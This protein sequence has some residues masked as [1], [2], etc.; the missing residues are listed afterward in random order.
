MAEKLLYFEDFSVGQRFTNGGYTISKEAAI[1]FAKQY[2]PQF[3]HTDEDAARK[4][5]FGRLTVCGMHTMAI[6]MRL[7]M[8]S[9]FAHVAGGLIGMGMEQM[10]WPRPVYPD[11]TLR[12]VIT[13]TSV[14]LSKSKPGSG[15]VHYILETFNQKDEVVLELHTAVIMPCRKNAAEH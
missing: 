2:D 8:T 5:F 7:K 1:A 9:D 13:V 6:T 3:L 15:I 12:I 10:K 11:D 14:R 4:G